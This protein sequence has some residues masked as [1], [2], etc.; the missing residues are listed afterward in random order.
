MKKTLLLAAALACSGVAQAEIYFCSTNG[1]AFVEAKEWYESRGFASSRSPNGAQEASNFV[2]DT[3]KGFRGATEEN[4]QYKGSCHTL[5]EDNYGIRTTCISE[6]NFVIESIYI[7]EE[8]GEIPF[9]YSHH[10][11]GNSVRSSAGICT[12]A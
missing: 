11:I 5:D 6:S 12:K 8:L 7:R 2:I 9:T 3:G 4:S 10:H 1:I